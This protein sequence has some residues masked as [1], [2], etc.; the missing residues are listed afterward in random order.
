MTQLLKRLREDPRAKQALRHARFGLRLFSAI[1]DKLPNKDDGMLQVVA[2]SVASFQAAYEAWEG[3]HR[4]LFDHLIEAAAKE[5]GEK[6]P[7]V[8]K[9]PVADGTPATTSAIRKWHAARQ[10]ELGSRPDSLLVRWKAA[11]GAPKCP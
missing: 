5:I 8:P 9:G 2:K 10:I 3:G 4:T 1:A 6:L 7:K 11:N